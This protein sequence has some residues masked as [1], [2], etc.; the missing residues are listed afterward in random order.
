MTVEITLFVKLSLFFCM[1]VSKIL[2]WLIQAV[3]IP[4]FLKLR[5]V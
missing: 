4:Y 1:A 3:I 5:D 2:I